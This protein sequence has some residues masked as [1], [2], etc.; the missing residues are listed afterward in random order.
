MI[1][2]DNYS[3]VFIELHISRSQIQVAWMIKK[4]IHQSPSWVHATHMR[5]MLCGMATGHPWGRTPN[6]P[7]HVFPS[8]RQSW[9][10]RENWSKEM[11]IACTIINV[12]V[13]FWP[14]RPSH[15][16]SSDTKNCYNLTRPQQCNSVRMHSDDYVPHWKVNKHFMYVQYGCGKQSKVV[17]TL[18]HDI[19][20]SFPLDSHPELP[21]SDPAS[22]V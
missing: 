1:Q 10:K 20:A 6:T 22:A 16:H 5:W 4:G 9:H 14:L 2:N 12:V 17:Y 13:L 18:N 19:M 3:N 21:K 11:L 8:T 7:Q 15:F